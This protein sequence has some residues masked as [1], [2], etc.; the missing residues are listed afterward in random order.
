MQTLNSG[1]KTAKSAVRAH[2]HA[3]PDCAH[4]SPGPNPKNPA[5]IPGIRPDS[6]R[7]RH[8]SQERQSENSGQKTVQN[9]PASIAGGDIHET[10]CISSRDWDKGRAWLVM[11][12][13]SCQDIWEQR[14]SCFAS[15]S[16]RFQIQPK[17]AQA[18]E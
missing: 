15:A 5:K 8:R 12:P 10:D 6:R 16:N 11:L 1:L 2:A 4:G 9:G 13:R 14:A 3:Q 18:N 7:P 17:M